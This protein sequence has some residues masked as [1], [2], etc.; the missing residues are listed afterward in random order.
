MLYQ[1]NL[2]SFC[3]LSCLLFKIAM[4]CFSFSKRA[5]AQKYARPR[6][7]FYKFSP[8]F[9]EC[10]QC[11]L[12]QIISLVSSPRVATPRDIFAVTLDKKVL[13]FNHLSFPP[14]QFKGSIFLDFFW[15][16]KCKESWQVWCF[17][18]QYFWVEKYRPLFLDNASKRFFGIVLKRG[19]PIFALALVW[20]K[21]QQILKIFK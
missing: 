10:F 2:F 12:S 15:K 3:L 17:W 14:V 11:V 20:K 7:L 19:A 5:S 18:I 4:H 1:K 8:G 16:I 13:H 21:Q 9:M 6:W